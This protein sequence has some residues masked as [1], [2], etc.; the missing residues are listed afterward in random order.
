MTTRAELDPA[1]TV[2]SAR[3]MG[4]DEVDLTPIRTYW[5]LVRMRFM[6]HRLAV[7]SLVILTVLVAYA[8]IV[9]FATGEAYKD[10]SLRK[11]WDGPEIIITLDPFEVVAFAPLGYDEIGQNVFIRLAKAT[12]TSL[13][14]GVAAVLIIAGIGS[15]VGALAG[16]L[17]GRVDNILM[18]FVDVVLSLP[19]LFIILMIVSFFGTG[20]VTVVIIAIG[21]TGWTLAAR[22]IRGEFLTLRETDFVMA[23]RALAV[24]HRRIVSRHMLP[25]AMGPL[26]VA[27]ALGVADSVVTEAALSFLGFGISPP[28]A[29]LG[30]MLNNAQT[31]FFRA[32]M[33][34]F[35]PGIVLVLIVLAASFLG[36]GLRD[37]LDPRQ[38]I[39]AA[40]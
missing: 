24:G 20:N 12:Q 14:I 17:G 7:I 31:Y 38:K 26:I 30:N 6:R 1:A 2:G 29:S 34:V 16:Y 3:S 8:V 5:Q 37:A 11:T 25:S 18:R 35:Y 22:L 40:S 15:L 10:P 4:E 33:L 39:E 23:A 36:D 21:I 19:V 13:I 9:P 27:S 32:P 28:E